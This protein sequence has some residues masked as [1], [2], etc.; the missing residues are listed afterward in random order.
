MNSKE[1]QLIGEGYSV[2]RSLSFRSIDGYNYVAQRILHTRKFW[3]ARSIR[4]RITLGEGEDISGFIEPAVAQ[5][6]FV[7]G[8]VIRQ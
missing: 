7:D 4:K 6:E 2:C 1:S 3:R 5:V 8:F